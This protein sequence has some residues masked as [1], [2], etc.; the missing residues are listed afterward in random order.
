MS[1]IYSETGFYV[2]LFGYALALYL[3]FFLAPYLARVFGNNGRDDLDLLQVK[4]K[5]AQARSQSVQAVKPVVSTTPELSDSGRAEDEEGAG[6]AVAAAP[7]ALTLV[8][9][10]LQ[11]DH[12]NELVRESAQHIRTQ[13]PTGSYQQYDLTLLPSYNLY[14][15]R[16]STAR[17]LAGVFVLLGLGMTMLRL[18]GVVGKISTMAASNAAMA[19]EDFIQQM[20]L[21]LRGIGGAF[22]ASIAG[23]FLMVGALVLIAILDRLKQREFSHIERSITQ[24][25][26]PMLYSIQQRELPAVTMPELL[27]VTTGQLGSLNEAVEKSVVAMTGEIG[28]ALSSLEAQLTTT[29]QRFGTYEDRYA[30]L[31]S[32]AEQIGQAGRKLATTIDRMQSS[33]H[34][35]AD[36]QDTLGSLLNTTRESYTHLG[37]QLKSSFSELANQTAAL[38]VSLDDVLRSLQNQMQVQRE[39]NLDFQ[40]ALR[41]QMTEGVDHARTQVDLVQAQVKEG[42]AGTQ[43]Q[44][45]E[46]LMATQVQA[47][48]VQQQLERVTAALERASNTRLQASLQQ[49]NDIT[50][51]MESGSATLERAL[52]QTQKTPPTLFAWT[53]QGLNRLRQRRGN[54]GGDG[55]IRV[56]PRQ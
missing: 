21:M 5:A 16:L 9:Q 15:E 12:T 2:V 23:L 29:F 14:S 4:L 55:A 18:N 50:A 17:A 30:K 49:L 7:D 34:K 56:G 27:R 36:F 26:I 22:S 24:D 40:Q 19:S 46:G 53:V 20:G 37:G 1:L 11:A 43:A 51:H 8:S 45:Q 44:V 52:R 47:E 25:L 6:D 28:G 35:Y 31:D 32:V 54:G 38:Q 48:R 39:E 42:L 41:Q 10:A 13:Y 33:T 3:P